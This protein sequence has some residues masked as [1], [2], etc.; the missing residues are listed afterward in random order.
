MH[1]PSPQKWPLHSPAKDTGRKRRG[2]EPAL[3]LGG[4]AGACVRGE[5]AR[6]G[7]V[8]RGAGGGAGSGGRGARALPEESSHSILTPFRSGAAPAGRPAGALGTR[9][10]PSPPRSPA[11]LVPRAA[12]PAP[13]GGRAALPAPLPAAL[14]ER[15]RPRRGCGRVRGAGSDAAGGSRPLYRRGRRGRTGERGCA[16]L[17]EAP[18]AVR[19][20][21][22]SAAA[23]LAAGWLPR[24]ASGRGAGRGAG[25]AAAAPPLGRAAVCA[26]GRRGA[27]APPSAGARVAAAAPV[28]GPR[29]A[30]SPAPGETL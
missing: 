6:R 8:S 29:L 1:F 18:G 20:P 16:R 19:A 2:E 24:P 21:P 26:R 28:P 15:G 4:R 27:G 14:G 11:R 13:D 3:L 25:R 9:R 12:R 7:E 22:A 17:R 10:R 30:A 23:D 5:R